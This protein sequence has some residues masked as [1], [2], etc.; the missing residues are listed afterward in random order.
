MVLTMIYVII[1]FDKYLIYAVSI[2]SFDS[3]V[4][5]LA[6]DWSIQSYTLSKVQ[7][8]PRRAS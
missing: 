7:H 4:S 1:V 5:E 3:S 8:S 6:D 2:I